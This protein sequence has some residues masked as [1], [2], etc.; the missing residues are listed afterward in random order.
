MLVILI[1][2]LNEHKVLRTFALNFYKGFEWFEKPYQR[3]K[4]VFHQVHVQTP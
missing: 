1:P 3:V 4:R 2:D